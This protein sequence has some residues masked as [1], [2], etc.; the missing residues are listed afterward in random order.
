ME[1]DIILKVKK[2]GVLDI[3]N[4]ILKL[5]TLFLFFF[6]L[7]IQSDE[8]VIQTGFMLVV[9]IVFEFLNDGEVEI[10]TKG[11]R[12]PIYGFTRWRDLDRFDIYKT[13]IVIK[14]KEERA[15]KIVIDLKEDKRNITNASKY[16]ESKMSKYE[17]KD[18]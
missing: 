13:T 16:V 5:Y 7:I 3:V 6:A 4:L 8:T 12:T 17:I 15:K 2:S 1:E 14:P 11:V 9:I 10:T 18:D